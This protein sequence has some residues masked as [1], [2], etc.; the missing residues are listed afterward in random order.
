M[1][2]PKVF[3]PKEIYRPIGMEADRFRYLV[4]RGTIKADAQ[5]SEMAGSANKFTAIE[6]IK[7]G[8]I[9]W[10]ERMGFTL[11]AAEKVTASLFA[12]PQWLYSLCYPLKAGYDLWL[13]ANGSIPVWVSR[14]DWDDIFK[15][16]KKTRM[17]T[18]GDGVDFEIVKDENGNIVYEE[19]ESKPLYNRDDWFLF[20]LFN[21]KLHLY[22]PKQIAEKL[23][24][25]NNISFY[26]ITGI[27]QET[28]ALLGVNPE[29]DID[30]GFYMDPQIENNEEERWRRN[31]EWQAKRYKELGID[32]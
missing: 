8:F 25:N 19:Y 24:N 4:K 7:A 22:I 11:E 29:V 30:T 10:S 27:F 20:S 18:K 31:Q 9:A 13:V 26:N 23:H 1:S 14:T 15:P 16:T 21:D 17:V 5:P 6:S 28:M 32:K 12:D 3:T 2:E